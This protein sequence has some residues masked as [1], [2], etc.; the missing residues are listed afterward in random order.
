MVSWQSSTNFRNCGEKHVEKIVK[1]SVDDKLLIRSLSCSVRKLQPQSMHCSIIIIII[2]MF[3]IDKLTK[4][5]SITIEVGI[6]MKSCN[7]KQSNHKNT[8]DCGTIR[9]FFGIVEFAGLEY[10]GLE[11]DGQSRRG[12]MCRTGK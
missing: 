6:S 11:D 1:C 5:N 3:F 9:R 10:A 8:E 12:G 2:I 7:H 4:R